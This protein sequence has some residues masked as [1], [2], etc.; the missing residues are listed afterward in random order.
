MELVGVDRCDRAHAAARSLLLRY[1]RPGRRPQG[2]SLS[3]GRGRPGGR[4][5]IPSPVPDLSTERSEDDRGRL[6]SRAIRVLR[7]H[8]YRTFP[9]G[10]A[11]GRGDGGIGVTIDTKVSANLA[12][13]DM[14]LGIFFAD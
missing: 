11:T 6:Y 14:R 13:S 1:R 4:R 2:L 9:G 8:R 12:V 10:G 5:G 7:P 3:Q